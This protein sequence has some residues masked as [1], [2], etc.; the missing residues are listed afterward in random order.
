MNYYKVSASAHTLQQSTK[1]QQV[2]S[3]LS[4]K[5]LNSSPTNVSNRDIQKIVKIIKNFGYWDYN[6]PLSEIL[7][8][9]RLSSD[10]YITSVGCLNLKDINL[11]RIPSQQLS[12][13]LSCV[14]SS[15]Y[16]QNVVGDL[17]NIGLISVGLEFN[18]TST[19]ISIN[20]R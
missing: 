19:S 11:Y 18:P 7:Q 6:P 9:A 20:L 3:F 4:T 8:A 16:M 10:G 2:T 14:G 1:V 15:V 17:A 13:L 5:Y 12:T